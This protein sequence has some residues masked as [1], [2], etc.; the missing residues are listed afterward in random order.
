[1]KKKS[2]LPALI[3]FILTTHFF[4]S[5]SAAT[6][7]YSYE[8]QGKVYRYFVV[9]SGD[10]YHFEFEETPETLHEQYTSG[11]YVLRSLYNDD[12]I[13]MENR[14]NYFRERAKWS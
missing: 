12:T 6:T 11:L 8:D 3:I 5:I 1:M 2:L 4:A 9:Q 14:K 10:N 13:K 7:E